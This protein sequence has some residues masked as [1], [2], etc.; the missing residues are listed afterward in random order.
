METI[1]SDRRSEKVECEVLALTGKHSIGVRRRSS[2]AKEAARRD[3]DREVED[4]LPQGRCSVHYKMNN[5]GKN[6][7]S[8]RECRFG[9][10]DRPNQLYRLIR[11]GRL[12][13]PGRYGGVSEAMPAP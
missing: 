10:E 9:K 13:L 8:F 6:V 11:C 4:L 12:R 5:E 7:K 3:S 2:G 1:Q